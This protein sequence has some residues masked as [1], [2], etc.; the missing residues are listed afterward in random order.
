MAKYQ[1]HIETYTMP[2]GCTSWI[3]ANHFPHLDDEE[4]VYAIWQGMVKE[5]ERDYPKATL[6]QARCRRTAEQAFRD[7][8]SSI[9]SREW[10]LSP[11]D[12]KYRVTMYVTKA[13]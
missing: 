10:V 4:R 11:K 13:A 3:T 12:G 9:C 6:H 2:V 1:F 7:R 5:V 8:E